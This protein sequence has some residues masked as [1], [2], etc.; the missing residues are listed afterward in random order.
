[1]EMRCKDTRLSRLARVR[2]SRRVVIASLVPGLMPDTK[3]RKHKDAK[4]TKIRVVTKHKKIRVVVH[5]SLVPPGW[6]WQNSSLGGSAAPQPLACTCAGLSSD[7]LVSIFRGLSH[8]ER[9]ACAQVC[10]QWNEA[11]AVCSLGRT[12]AKTFIAHR[13]DKELTA[14]PKF[15]CKTM[16]LRRGQRSAILDWLVDLHRRLELLPEALPFA[17]QVFDRF[18]EVAQENTACN[19]YNYTQLAGCCLWISSKFYGSIGT[20]FCYH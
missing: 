10:K 4:R 17:V 15:G 20:G 13:R 12:A 19:D 7:L 18:V 9:F 8:V 3:P 6:S 11:I 1:M 16:S 2:C 5:S 14:R